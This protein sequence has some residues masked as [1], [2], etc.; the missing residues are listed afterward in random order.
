MPARLWPLGVVLAV[1]IGLLALT[2]A[3]HVQARLSG[4]PITLQTRPLDPYDLLSGYHVELEY[5]VE[6]RAHRALQNDGLERGDRFWIRLRRAEPA[7]EFAG[8]SRRRPELA[9]DKEVAVPAT[10]DDGRVRIVGA[11]RLYVPETQRKEAE[12][13]SRS[14]YVD[15]RVGEDGTVALL[16]MRIG[17]RVF[18]D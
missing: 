6:Q 14:A 10:Y 17:G 3:R 15:A 2:P 1:Q 11:G 5:E 18:G 12:Q 4:T 9:S 13:A 7:W 16:R 8:V